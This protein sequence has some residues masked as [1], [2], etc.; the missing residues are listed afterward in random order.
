[1]L[2]ITPAAVAEP[3]RR[4][5]RHRAPTSAPPRDRSDR[6]PWLRLAPR[7]ATCG[8]EEALAANRLSLA[9][10]SRITGV[11]EA[12]IVK[13]AEWAYAPKPS[14]TPGNRHY[15]RTMH[16]YEKGIIWGQRQLPH[17]VRLGRPGAGHRERRPSRDRCRAHGRPSGGLC[18]PALSGRAVGDLCRRRDHQGQ[19]PHAHGLGLQCL[20]DH[21]ELGAVPLLG[22]QRPHQSHLAD[23]LSRSLPQVPPRPL[24]DVTGGAE[25]ARRQG[26]RRRGRRHRRAIQRLRLD[27]RDGLPRART[28]RPVRC[29]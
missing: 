14:S 21:A 25:P 12:D 9:E 28:S 2:E 29:S 17:P 3:A 10:C 16:G 27:V 11:P 24:P 7:T 18:A 26:L 13:A 19:R 20:P 15:P 22:Q 4:G 5:R 23:R 1:M 8:F 6:A